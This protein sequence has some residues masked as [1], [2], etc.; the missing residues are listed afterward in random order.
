MKTFKDGGA[1]AV[2]GSDFV[3]LQTSPAV[4]FEEG[5]EI[6]QKLEQGGLSILST[7]ELI[8]TCKALGIGVTEVLKLKLRELAELAVETEEQQDL[9]ETT[10]EVVKAM[11]LYQDFEEASLRAKELQGKIK[12]L[13]SDVNSLTIEAYRQ[14]KEKKPVSGVGVRVGKALVYDVEKAREFCLAELPQ[15][16]K[17]D[18]SVFEK[19]AKGVQ[20]VKPLDFVNIEEKVTATIAGDLSE[21]KE[22]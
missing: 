18:T 10:F 5:S 6:Y 22:V 17:L 16:L 14:T 15:A 13:R 2:V 20:E 7:E 8:S 4:W 12:D 1:I 11:P 9:V 3:D 19:Y 21:Y